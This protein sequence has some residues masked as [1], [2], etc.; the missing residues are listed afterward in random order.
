[1]PESQRHLRHQIR[2]ML[3]GRGFGT[4]GPGLWIAPDFVYDPLRRELERE[5]LADFVEF[6]AADVMGHDP[7]SRVAEWWDLG[8]LAHLYAGFLDAFEALRLRWASAPED[9]A[10]A[11]ADYVRLLTAWR[12]LPYLDP[13]LP[14]D[15]LPA[16]WQGVAAEGLFLELHTRLAGPAARHAAAVIGT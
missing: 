16:D 2:R 11:F 13:G 4:V 3:A 10:R 12:R 5:G 7:A 14:A 8:A 9:D 15:Y 1:V 6:F